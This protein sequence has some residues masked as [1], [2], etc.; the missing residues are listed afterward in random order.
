MIWLA[1]LPMFCGIVG[2]GIAVSMAPRIQRDLKTNWGEENRTINTLVWV[3]CKTVDEPGEFIHSLVY[4]INTKYNEFYK[5][6]KNAIV[7]IIQKIWFIIIAIFA[8]VVVIFIVTVSS[9]F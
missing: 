5:N 8:I 2:L 7:S 3:H 9:I 1:F 4:S 6:L